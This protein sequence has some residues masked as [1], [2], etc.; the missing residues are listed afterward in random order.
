MT[1]L[2]QPTLK[3]QNDL[4]KLLD[5][6]RF[7]D[8]SLKCSDNVVL[9][10]CKNIICIRSE[11]L[12]DYIFNK[13]KKNNNQIEF[14]KIN[15]T[16]MRYILEYLYTDKNE[17]EELSVDN[18]IEIYYSATY[19]E[20]DDLKDEIIEFTKKLLEDGDEDLGKILLS[21]CI[22]KFSLK[23]DNFM[24]QLLVDWVSKI[25][26]FPNDAEKD[27]LSLLGLEYLLAKTFDTE[28][29]FATYELE[30]FEYCSNKSKQI[31]SEG[32]K[33]D[34][35]MGPY[36]FNYESSKIQKIMTGFAPLLNFID[37]N[38][39]NH[40]DIVKKIEPLNI[41]PPEIITNAYRY[42]LERIHEVSRP[43]RGY[44]IF[45]WKNFDNEIWQF[46]NKLNI[47]KNGFTLEADPNLKSY[48]SI[49]GNIIIK[50]KGY[51]KW[52]ILI[53]NLTDLI[54]IG[55]CE[56]NSQFNK[57]Y[58]KGFRGWALGSDG[59]VYNEKTCKWNNAKFK[60]NDLVSVIVNMN[61]KHCYFA[62]NGTIH[63]DVIGDSF[64]DQ[65]YPFVSLKK[66][67]KLRV[68]SY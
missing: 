44:L 51:H 46:E 40:E 13:Q 2:T 9:R 18:V 6:E 36:D 24:T 39:I 67:S 12:N 21:D 22:G 20:L 30:I 5:D 56:T 34:L 57:P 32:K 60:E 8:I 31:L 45:K 58:T 3:F 17:R 25:Q 28:K 4:S 43:I 62:V 63:Y 37:L 68:Q 61:T 41:F 50:G 23:T 49:M 29:S 33:L 1:S 54:Y 27:S 15:S 38:R 26:L 64:P 7:F 19:F 10:A 52:D 16:A 35:K 11:V 66:G 59:Y 42:K 48:K 55:I 65:V 47:T 14:D 53:E